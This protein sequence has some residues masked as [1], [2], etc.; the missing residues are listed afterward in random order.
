MEKAINSINMRSNQHNEKCVDFLPF[1]EALDEIATDL[2][3]PSRSLFE[4]LPFPSKD[5]PKHSRISSI[6][7]LAHYQ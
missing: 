1:T 7:L 6:T 2:T 5:A 4:I 3:A